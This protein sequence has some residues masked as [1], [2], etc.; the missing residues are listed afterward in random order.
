MHTRVRACACMDTRTHA[1]MQAH[2]YVRTHAH[3]VHMRMD[4]HACMH[5]ARAR[6]RLCRLLV[7]WLFGCLVG[8]RK[9]MPCISSCS[10][11]SPTTTPPPYGHMPLHT[12]VRISTHMPVQVFPRMS[13]HMSP[14]MSIPK[15]TYMSTASECANIVMTYI[16]MVY[17]VMAYIAVAYMVIGVFSHPCIPR[18]NVPIRVCVS[19]LGTA[20]SGCA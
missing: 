2:T 11:S 8:Y 14:R 20:A 9:P 16:V 3:A 7:V 1:N 19:V 4:A 18:V 10:C 17:I 6:V 13:I 12:S 15:S 5:A